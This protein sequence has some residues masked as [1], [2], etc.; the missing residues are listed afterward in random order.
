[1]IWKIFI[2][3]LVACVSAQAF[4]ETHP[5]F[6][7]EGWFAFNAIYGFLACAALIL[8]AK[9]IGVFLKRRDDYYDE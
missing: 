6:A 4:V 1:M 5:H 7:F 2:A 3:T 8:V 9:G